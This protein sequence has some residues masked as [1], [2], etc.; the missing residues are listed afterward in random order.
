MYPGPRCAPGPHCTPWSPPS[1][2]PLGALSPQNVFPWAMGDCGQRGAP[3]KWVLFWGGGGLI[4]SWE[5]GREW[6]PSARGVALPPCCGCR[7]PGTHFHAPRSVGMGKRAGRRLW[8][9]ARLI[10]PRGWH[11]DGG[12]RAGRAQPLA[13]GR[14]VWQSSCPCADEAVGP[15]G[16]VNYSN[17]GKCVEQRMPAGPRMLAVMCD[18]FLPARLSTQRGWA[19]LGCP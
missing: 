15:L 17:I 14:S 13:R 19:G 5:L 9:P 4:L 2:L 18:V 8:L 7:R 10:S 12:R 3:P 11:R 6:S 16:S 1:A